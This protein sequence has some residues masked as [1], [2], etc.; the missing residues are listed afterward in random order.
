MKRKDC[1]AQSTYVFWCFI[2]CNYHLSNC[3]TPQV[4]TLF[5]G[6]TN[7]DAQ[8]QWKCICTVFVVPVWVVCIHLLYGLSHTQPDH[9]SK[10]LNLPGG[11]VA[12]DC[13]ANNQELVVRNR[14]WQIPDRHSL[15]GDWLSTNNSKSNRTRAEKQN[16]RCGDDGGDK[17]GQFSLSLCSESSDNFWAQHNKILK[18]VNSNWEQFFRCL[19][20]F[21]FCLWIGKN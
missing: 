13:T 17:P 4:Y 15:P 20:G 2:Y 16:C 14:N 19:S 21:F 7:H 11:A 3:S 18:M 12:H 5:N 10:Q 6:P 9:T 1:A 8:K